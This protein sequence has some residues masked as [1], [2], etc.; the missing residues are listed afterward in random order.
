M[1]PTTTAATLQRAYEAAVQT[2]GTHI[3]SCNAGCSTEGRRCLVAE[4]LREVAQA[5][6]DARGA[7]GRDG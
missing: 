4:R 1:T 3:T 6:Q 2:L 5:A 7:G